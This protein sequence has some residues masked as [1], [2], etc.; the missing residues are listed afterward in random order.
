MVERVEVAVVEAGAGRLVPVVAAA[1]F[2]AVAVVA[3]AGI[4]GE[5]LAGSMSG[6]CRDL[7]LTCSQACS[8]SKPDI[9][10]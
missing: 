1:S 5:A 3:T 6:C 8:H 9:A 10:V 4:A 7:E 2:A